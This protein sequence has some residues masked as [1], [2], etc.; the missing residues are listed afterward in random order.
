MKYMLIGPVWLEI[1]EFSYKKLISKESN[2]EQASI[3]T[4]FHLKSI[5]FLIN[6]DSLIHMFNPF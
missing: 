3:W 1:S 6:S 2:K 4:C 5:I